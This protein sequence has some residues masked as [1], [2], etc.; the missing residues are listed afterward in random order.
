MATRFVIEGRVQGVGYRDWCQREAQRRGLD[1][2]VRNLRDGRVEA[3]FV[4]DHSA[5]DDML[6]ACRQGP[7]S[8]QVSA[9]GLDVTDDP[10]LKGFIVLPDA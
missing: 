10:G 4:G 3:V 7:P 1:G 5:I 9:I 2:F 6:S 8:A